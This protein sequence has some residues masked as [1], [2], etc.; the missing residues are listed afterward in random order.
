MVYLKLLLPGVYLI[1]KIIRC[2]FLFESEKNILFLVNTSAYLK[3]GMY[4]FS[5]QG[6][7]KHRMK[8]KT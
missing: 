5:S 6:S 7:V 8:I 4:I 1:K 3:E 2:V